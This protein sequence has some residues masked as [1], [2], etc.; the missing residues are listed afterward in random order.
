MRGQLLNLG[1]K[2]CKDEN[3]NASVQFVQA[4]EGKEV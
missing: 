1:L 2:I 3:E 4:Y